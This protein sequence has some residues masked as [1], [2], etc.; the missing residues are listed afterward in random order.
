MVPGESREEVEKQE[1]AVEKFYNDDRKLYDIDY[2]E[3][4]REFGIDGD[5]YDS[6]D[7]CWSSIRY[8][9]FYTERRDDY[10]TCESFILQI[11]LIVKFFFIFTRI[12]FNDI[13]DLCDAKIKESRINRAKSRTS[14]LIMKGNIE[15]EMEYLSNSGHD[16]LKQVFDEFYQN[17]LSS[18]E[19]SC[20]DAHSH[21]CSKIRSSRLDMNYIGGGYS[22]KNSH[23]RMGDLAGPSGLVTVL[24]SH[25]RPI[26]SV[27]RLLFED[28]ILG[29]FK[30]LKTDIETA[31]RL[32]SM[33]LW[34]D[35]ILFQKLQNKQERTLVPFEVVPYN[36]EKVF[37]SLG[38]A[39]L[40]R[41]FADVCLCNILAAKSE[42]GYLL[43]GNSFA[44]IG[45]NSAKYHD[46]KL[47][48]HNPDLIAPMTVRVFENKTENF[49]ATMMLCAKVYSTLKKMETGEL[50]KTEEEM[51][52][53]KSTFYKSGKEVAET[54]QS[55]A[56]F[57]H[58]D[59]S[60]FFEEVTYW[61]DYEELQVGFACNCQVLVFTLKQLEELFSEQLREEFN[62]KSK[63][64]RLVLKIYDPV[65]KTFTETPRE[66]VKYSLAR[67]L[68]E[69]KENELNVYQRIREFNISQARGSPKINAPT[70]YK[71]GNIKL[72]VKDNEDFFSGGYIVMDFLEG[73]VTTDEHFE[74]GRKQAALFQKAGIDKYTLRFSSVRVHNDEVYFIGHGS[75][76]LTSRDSEYKTSLLSN[77]EMYMESRLS[78]T[79]K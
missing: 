71:T 43:D 13:E 63:D 17:L 27:M 73:V 31:G 28:L 77:W 60:Y 39:G 21:S 49:T 36:A 3:Y 75:S 56:R 53:Y 54:L 38:K 10:K 8:S 58:M 57:Y 52:S 66:L 24:D 41:H 19:H 4:L 29:Q 50:K 12:A 22:Y 61:G 74:K 15:Y 67:G 33:K 40:S 32:R 46:M 37:E 62:I 65:R 55:A 72:T 7:E 25:L 44:E 47:D 70:I 48:I 51:D 20:H 76:H 16:E 14:K 79:L 68:E 30:S 5:S 2:R 34:P 64:H 59:K 42:V 18:F 6:I 69:Y 45:F 23:C 35:F 11:K 1:R 9:G 78:G 26:T